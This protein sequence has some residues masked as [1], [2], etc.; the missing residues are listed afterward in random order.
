MCIALFPFIY[1]TSWETAYQPP[2]QPLA[3]MIVDVEKKT[4]ILQVEEQFGILLGVHGP[5]ADEDQR[6]PLRRRPR[7]GVRLRCP[8]LAAATVPVGRVR[9]FFFEKYRAYEYNKATPVSHGRGRQYGRFD[10]FCPQAPLAA[11]GAFSSMTATEQQVCDPDQHPIRQT[12]QARLSTGRSWWE[13]STGLP[14]SS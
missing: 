5:A 7:A 11:A 12:R 9:G 1:P 13:R 14:I 2:R 8:C 10:R 6:P 3:A 4:G